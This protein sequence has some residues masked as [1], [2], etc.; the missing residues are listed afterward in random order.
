[1]STIV[2]MPG[3]FHPFHAGHASLYQAAVK[4]FPG[5]DQLHPDAFGALVSLVFNR[6]SAVTGTNREEMMGIRTLI[7]S[8]DYKAISNLI[9]SM[10]HIWVGKG[11]DGLLKRRD[12][13]SA[14]V[15]SCI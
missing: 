7:S 5:A 14:L 6:G 13:E 9:T 2:V 15:R 4:A 1:M 3:G 8:K 11:L 10:K 12:D